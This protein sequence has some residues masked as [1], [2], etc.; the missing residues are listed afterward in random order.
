[1]PAIFPIQIAWPFICTFVAEPAYAEHID[2]GQHTASIAT[3]TIT[4]V[5]YNFPGLW[6]NFF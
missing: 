4:C 5:Y 3:G 2:G 1:M 6:I